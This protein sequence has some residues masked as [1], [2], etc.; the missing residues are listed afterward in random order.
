MSLGEELAAAGITPSPTGTS[1]VGILPPKPKDKAPAPPPEAVATALSQ[2][3]KALSAATVDS[4]SGNTSVPVIPAVVVAPPTSTQ[5]QP[6]KPVEP[7]LPNQPPSEKAHTN[8]VAVSSS[9]QSIDDEASEP[10]PLSSA[11][12]AASQRDL[13]A[14]KLQG[15]SAD[16]PKQGL[17]D[18]FV[19]TPSFGPR[20][21]PSPMLSPALNIPGV[22]LFEKPKIATCHC[23]NLCVIIRG[24][25]TEMPGEGFP[26]LPTLPWSSS[27]AI[28]LA[29]EPTV[30]CQ[31]FLKVL[32]SLSNSHCFLK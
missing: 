18:S 7:Q 2:D 9:S 22:I 20:P 27:K 5:T 16:T 26:T 6:S 11:A 8:I 28:A 30:V 15:V 13:L 29:C 1:P 4:S 3:S 25:Y 23:L 17:V 31:F 21:S 32:I 19:R 10:K 12:L 24:E 14:G